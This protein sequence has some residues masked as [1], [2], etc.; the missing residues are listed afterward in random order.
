MTYKYSFLFSDN[1][2][3][4]NGKGTAK[5]KKKVKK[6]AKKASAIASSDSEGEEEVKHSA[7]EPEEGE[8]FLK[9]TFKFI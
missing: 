7:S 2:W 1:Q 6:P 3:T 5:K 8:I 4:V 9:R